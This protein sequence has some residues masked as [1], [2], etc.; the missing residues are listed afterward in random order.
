MKA[1]LL[2]L[3]CFV[4]FS[5]VCVAQQTNTFGLL[6]AL[7]LKTRLP[8]DWFVNFKTESRQQIQSDD[9]NLSYQLTD[10]SIGGGKKI[11]IRTTIAGSYLFSI[12]D[13][14]ATSSRFTQQIS[15][16]EDYQLIKL[17]HRLSTDQSIEKD[18]ANKYRLRYR[19]SG[20]IPLSGQYLDPTEFFIKISNEYLNSLQ[21]N[22]YDLEIRT[23]VFLGYAVSPK[24]K[25]EFGLDHRMTSIISEKKDRFWIRLNIYQSF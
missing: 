14:G 18:H 4:S 21:E 13:E 2:L 16:I 12:E 5:E 17:A 3:I 25:L 9:F 24:N 15:H 11:G 20:E 6:S 8:K 22:R 10:L 7:N 1:F 19:L 23:A